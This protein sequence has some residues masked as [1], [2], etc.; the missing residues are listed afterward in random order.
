MT[1]LSVASRHPS[2]CCSRVSP[3]KL[4]VVT[5]KLVMDVSERDVIWKKI[6]SSS[7][8]THPAS[9]Y[10]PVRSQSSHIPTDKS[11]SEF[12]SNRVH[13]WVSSQELVSQWERE[14]RSTALMMPAIAASKMSTNSEC[15]PQPN[16]LEKVFNISGSGS[17][18]LRQLIKNTTNSIDGYLPF[19][20]FFFFLS[21]FFKLVHPDTWNSQRSIVIVKKLDFLKWISFCYPGSSS[22]VLI[23]PGS[24]PV[25]SGVE[26]FLHSFVTRRRRGDHSAFYKMRTGGF[27]RGW[28]RPSVELATLPLPSAVAV[29]M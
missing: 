9:M 6:Q 25:A 14:Y 8:V 16:G 7:A 18:R 17:E 24:I 10:H 28:R 20:F 15:G 27:P 21:F 3:A 22:A 4:P 13:I 1:N 29:Y 5:A 12:A 26:I 11:Q 19:L 2:S 23:G